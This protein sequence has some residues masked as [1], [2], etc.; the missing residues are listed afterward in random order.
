MVC[1]ALPSPKLCL[2]IRNAV[3]QQLFVGNQPQW[4][5]QCW[6]D[7]LSFG[8]NWNKHIPQLREGEAPE[9]STK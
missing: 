2:R 1:E 8:G 4:H 5:T 6:G 9:E 7:D 3:K